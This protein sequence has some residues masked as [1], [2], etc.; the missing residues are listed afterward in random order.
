MG[1]GGLAL[2]LGF[3]KSGKKTTTPRSIIMQ[4]LFHGNPEKKEEIKEI[5][6]SDKNGP[7]S[8]MIGLDTQHH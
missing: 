4:T 7:N 6:I 8:E 1:G 2:W 3:Q 5:H